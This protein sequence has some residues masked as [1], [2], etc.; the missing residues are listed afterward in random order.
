MSFIPYGKQSINDENIDAVTKILKLDFLTTGPKIKEFENAIAQYSEAEYCVAVE[1]GTV[2]LHLAS[3]CLLKIDDKVLTISNSFLATS[4]SILYVGA[5][6]IFIDIAKDGNIDLDLCE[7]ELTKDSSIR[8]IY[9]VAF[10]GNMVDQNKL[11]Y[12]SG[13]ITTNSK[14]IYEKL[15][16]SKTELY[17]ILKNKKIVLQIH[18]MPINKQPYYKSL[19]YGEEHIPKMDKYYK[20]CFSLPMYPLLTNTEQEYVINTLLEI[21]NA[22]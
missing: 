3:L 18:Y 1:N 19:G 20:E 2:A 5:V 13:A 8:A 9:S 14:D 4:N 17:N 16:I 7:N 15:N 10:S 22:K 11:E 21:L 6:P 12:L